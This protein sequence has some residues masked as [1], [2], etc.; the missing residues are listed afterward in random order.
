VAYAT[1]GDGETAATVMGKTI[2]A[3]KQEKVPGETIAELEKLSQQL[4]TES[5]P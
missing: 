2:Q 4:S 3:A 1:L 5:K